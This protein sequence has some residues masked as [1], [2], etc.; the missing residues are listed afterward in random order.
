M[1]IDI[2]IYTWIFCHNDLAY[3]SISIAYSHLIT[4]KGPIELYRRLSRDSGQ[5]PSYVFETR[6]KATSLNSAHL[7][8]WVAKDQNQ[9]KSCWQWDGWGCIHVVLCISTF[10]VC[11]GVSSGNAENERCSVVQTCNGCFW[12]I[13]EGTIVARKAPTSTATNIWTLRTQVVRIL[14]LF[15]QSDNGLTIAKLGW[16]K[17]F[18][19]GNE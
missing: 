9:Q 2:Y 1:Y 14:N 5:T 7:A 4:S 17:H 15:W 11:P 12:E 19:E 3:W 8:T 13:D 18:F 6:G 10:S 16:W